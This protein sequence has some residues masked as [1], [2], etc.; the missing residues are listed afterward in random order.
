VGKVAVTKENRLQWGDY[1]DVGF[2]LPKATMMTI[3]L[4]GQERQDE[5]MLSEKGWMGRWV[6]VGVVMRAMVA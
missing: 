4:M 2:A 6:L 1:G 5:M 3:S